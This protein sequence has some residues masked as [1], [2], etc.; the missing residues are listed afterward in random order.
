M[1]YYWAVHFRLNP[2]VLCCVVVMIG[3]TNP[4]SYRRVLDIF[5]CGVVNLRTFS[6]T[7]S[8]TDLLSLE[9]DVCYLCSYPFNLL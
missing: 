7:T 6:L 8:S 4:I 9:N 2:K 5:A 1:V 3:G